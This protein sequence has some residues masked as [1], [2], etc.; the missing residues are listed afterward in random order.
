MKSVTIRDVAKAAGVSAATVS[1][2]FNNSGRGGRPTRRAVLSGVRS[3]HYVAN[4]NARN[5]AKDASQTLGMI[6]SDI[7]NPFFPEVIKGFEQ[8]ARDQTYDVILSETN[9]DSAVL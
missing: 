6:V 7:E 9:Y 3:L 1:Y 4:L 2:L 8:K 5:L